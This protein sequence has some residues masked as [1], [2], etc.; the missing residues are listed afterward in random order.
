M[1]INHV[2]AVVP[3]TDIAV[4]R[5]FYTT[6]FD[7]EPDNNPMPNLIEW[8]LVDGGWLQ[9]FQDDRRAGS[10]MLN[11]AVD[12]LAE[13]RGALTERGLAPGEIEE[14]SKGVQLSVITDPEG[15]CQP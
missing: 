5:K 8:Q 14:V 10:G 2:L 11:L 12:D 4:A 9:V 7:R 1:S 6:L 13:Q 15:N 3:V